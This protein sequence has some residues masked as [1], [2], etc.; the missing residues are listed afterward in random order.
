MLHL[1]QIIM[2]A[3]SLVV[4]HLVGDYLFQEDGMA[5]NK[6]KKPGDEDSGPVWCFMHALLYTM[7]HW[8]VISAATQTIELMPW[9]FY[10]VVGGTHFLIDRYNLSRIWMLAFNQKGFMTGACAPWSKIVVDNSIHMVINFS[11]FAVW[12]N[13]HFANANL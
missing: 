2:V 10:A 7:A 1:F 4:A 13:A 3:S 6:V 5:G 8:V 11:M 9:W 12:A